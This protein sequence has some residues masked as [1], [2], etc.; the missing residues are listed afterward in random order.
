MN[1]SL[2]QFVL[3]ARDA[4]NRRRSLD[5]KYIFDDRLKGNKKYLIILTGYKQY[6]H[7]I[8][9][10]RLL[11]YLPDDIDVCLITSGKLDNEIRK[12]AKDMEWSYLSTS[13]NKVAIAQ[14]LAITLNKDAEYIYKMDED[15]FLTEN[16]F[17]KLYDDFQLISSEKKVKIG[18]IAPI[19]PLNGFGYLKILDMY[20]LRTEYENK[21]ETAFLSSDSKT[22]LLSDPDVAEFF[23]GKGG[24]LKN[25][26][27]INKDFQQKTFE[28][29]LCPIRYSIG[30]ILFRKT[31]W[32]N[33]GMFR[34]PIFNSGMGEDEKQICEFCMTESM[35]IT[36]PS[37]VVVGHFSF[38]PQ[39]KKMV[40]FLQSDEMKYYWTDI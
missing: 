31:L 11:K 4:N 40:E 32:E 23:W 18:F 36:V 17:E 35:P 10:G 25:I 7:K 2:T 39:T 15:I 14:N 5:S 9:F 37:N 27:E 6:L 3:N 24:S 22:K 8:V 28:Y 33:M 19:M 34:A 29:Y 1:T 20:G 21:F 12:F 16:C 30:F 38:G 13:K 26:D